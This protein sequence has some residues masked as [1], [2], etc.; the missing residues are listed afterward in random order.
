MANFSV[1]FITKKGRIGI[2]EGIDAVILSQNNEK[3]IIPNEDWKVFYASM[4]IANK[5]R[6]NK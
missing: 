1:S 3:V 2:Y 5:K 6:R 4:K